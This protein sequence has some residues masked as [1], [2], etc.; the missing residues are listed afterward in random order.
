MKYCQVLHLKEPPLVNLFAYKC[1]KL[2][3]RQVMS[4]HDKL[5][6][7]KCE[8]SKVVKKY[9]IHNARTNTFMKNID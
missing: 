8:I 3:Y 2:S 6:K 1:F 5:F 9:I 7:A 4:K